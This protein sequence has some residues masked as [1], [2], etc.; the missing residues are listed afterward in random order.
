MENNKNSS[1]LFLS[2]KATVERRVGRN[3]SWSEEI[4]IMTA[5]ESGFFFKTT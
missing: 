2:K 1:I 3:Q 4:P 5:V